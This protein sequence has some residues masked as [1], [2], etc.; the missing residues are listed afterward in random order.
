MFVDGLQ[1]M[2][3]SERRFST[4]DRRLHV[5]PATLSI[6]AHHF[7]VQTQMFVFTSIA[8]V[9]DPAAVQALGA[10]ERLFSL[11]ENAYFKSKLDVCIYIKCMF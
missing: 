1:A 7:P 2:G 6:H 4:L 8:Y 9:K 3:A 10:N 5:L 11:L